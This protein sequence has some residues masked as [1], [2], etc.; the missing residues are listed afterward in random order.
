MEK[1]TIVNKQGVQMRVSEKLAAKLGGVKPK[2][3][4][5]PPELVVQPEVVEPVKAEPVKIEVITPEINPLES[6]ATPVE[7]YGGQDTTAKPEA[8]KPVKKAAPRKR[9]RR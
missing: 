9:S 3:L 7:E 6:T 4:E 2:I 5:K 8:P 1:V